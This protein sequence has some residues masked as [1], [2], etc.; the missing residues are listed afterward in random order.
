V[1]VL[2][3]AG[4]RL[5]RV[6]VDAG[7]PGALSTPRGQVDQAGHEGLSG[8]AAVGMTQQYL[9][10]EMSLLVAELQAAAANEGFTRDLACLRQ[11]AEKAPPSALTPVAVRALALGD[12]LCWDSLSQG[13]VAAFSRQCAAVAGLREF[14]TCAGLLAD[15]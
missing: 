3:C 9:V 14:C 7:L 2:P 11:E 8:W 12:G 1:K 5:L 15:G 10:G 4:E 13:N 6:T